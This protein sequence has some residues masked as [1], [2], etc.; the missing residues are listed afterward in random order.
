MSLMRNSGV[1]G[2]KFFV[3]IVKSIRTTVQPLLKNKVVQLPFRNG[4]IHGSPKYVDHA[5]PEQS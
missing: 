1:L 5:K 3:S 2:C 4:S